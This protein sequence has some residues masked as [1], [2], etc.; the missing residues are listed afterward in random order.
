MNM[1]MFPPIA[2]GR[3]AHPTELPIDPDERRAVAKALTD[4]LYNYLALPI[5][6]T[7]R[8]YS[9]TNRPAPR[10]T[11]ESVMEIQRKIE[12]TRDQIE[13]AEQQLA[14]STAPIPEDFRAM[15]Y[16]A[17]AQLTVTPLRNQVKGLEE[18]LSHLQAEMEKQAGPSAAEVTP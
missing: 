17:M 18:Y 14:D 5:A 9:L 12:E 15:M 6:E 16:N 4:A 13:I 2:F 3:A 7:E 8:A 11:L 10:V 1:P